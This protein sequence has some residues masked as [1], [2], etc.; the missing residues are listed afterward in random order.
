MKRIYHT[1]DKGRKV[2]E[3]KLT[4]CLLPNGQAPLSRLERIEHNRGAVGN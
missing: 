2:D 4:E 1:I 3:P